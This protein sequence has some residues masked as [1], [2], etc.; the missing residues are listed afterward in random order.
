MQAFEAL[1]ALA[2]LPQSGRQVLL[3]ARVRLEDDVVV[4]H[5]LS[6]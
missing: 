1:D 2:E 6:P 5:D 3:P 4:Q